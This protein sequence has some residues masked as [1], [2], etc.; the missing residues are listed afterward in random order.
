MACP[1]ELFWTHTKMHIF[2]YFAQGKIPYG[3]CFTFRKSSFSLS[4]LPSNNTLYIAFSHLTVSCIINRPVQSTDMA[5]PLPPL[6][7]N[8][9][10]SQLLPQ[11]TL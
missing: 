4:Y 11:M 2:R 3:A 9:N 8:Y 10:N 6:P 5:P 7:P 1:P